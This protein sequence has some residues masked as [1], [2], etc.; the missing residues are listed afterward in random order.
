MIVKD[1][2]SQIKACLQSFV[3]FADEIIVVDTGSKDKTVELAK[4][5][6]DK[7]KVFN[8]EWVDDFSKARN[9][10]IEK[11]TSDWVL[12]VDA[13]EHIVPQQLELIKERIQQTVFSGFQLIQRTYSNDS[14]Q[15]LWRPISSDLAKGFAGYVD[16]PVLRLFRN[17][18]HFRFTGCVH[19]DVTPSIKENKGAMT[20][21]EI[22][23]HHYEYL[24]GD[25][26]VGKKQRY[27]LMLSLK[28]IK[29]MPDNPKAYAD[30]GI[31]LFNFVESDTIELGGEIKNPKEEALVYFRK[32]I[33]FDNKFAIAY[34]YIAKI[35]Q[36]K[37]DI[38]GAVSIL[39]KSVLNGV[40]DLGIYYN[41]AK[42][43]L[44]LG[45]ESKAISVFKD[46]IRISPNDWKLY[47][48]IAL[49]AEKAMD[50]E[51]AIENYKVLAASNHPDKAK[52]AEKVSFL[53]A[54]SSKN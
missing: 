18:P 22:I 28:K 21:S 46:A 50:T 52:F 36:E 41:L 25:E 5:V 9:F 54:N 2:G 3:D 17:N 19:E 53:E 51:L 33:E 34:N 8:F 20:V 1:E 39:Q 16:V 23:L 26:A 44:N 7:V 4:A 12:I 10:S 31:I 42:L 13:D 29:E 24:K 45:K 6:S 30:A 32:A 37:G 11:A 14:K 40:T 47:Y 35:L 15:G 27:Y 48:N 43:Y 38:E 49:L